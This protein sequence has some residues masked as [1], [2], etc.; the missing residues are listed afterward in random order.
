MIPTI[1]LIRYSLAALLLWAALSLHAFAF[2]CTNLG[3]N[4]IT[5]SGSS[6]TITG[7]TVPAGSL[8]VGIGTENDG[9]STG[10]TI[11]DGTNGNYTG[12]AASGNVN[13]TAGAVW[14]GLFYFPNSASLSSATITYTLAAALSGS[15]SA[16]L[17]ACYITGALTV[18]PLDTVVTATAFGV[19]NSPSVTSGAPSATDMLIGWAVQASNNTFSQ[20]ST[21]GWAAP[22]NAI[23][24]TGTAFG[25]GSQ[26][27]GSSKIFNPT[28]SSTSHSYWIA[29]VGFKP[30]ATISPFIFTP[31]ILP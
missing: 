5:G 11:K 22:P 13:N 15:N 24:G 31:S 17:S 25:A 3:T 27:S 29:V 1:R 4:S 26:V 7:V 6:V 10:G 21:H 28:F 20:D 14:T 16:T 30:A 19:S 18:S 12:P 23:S 2:S 8:I 9:T